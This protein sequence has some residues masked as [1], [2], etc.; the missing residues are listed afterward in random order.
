MRILFV[1]TRQAE[2]FSPIALT[3][4]VFEL[5]CGTRSIRQRMLDTL[6]PDSWGVVVRPHLADVYRQ[7]FP[8]AHV[9]D[10]TW[11]DAEE[12][13]IVN[14]LW[15]VD[16]VLLKTLPLETIF[17][18]DEVPLAWLRSG[19]PPASTADSIQELLNAIPETHATLPCSE[20]I[21][22]RYPWDLIKHNGA[23]L[24][25]DFE[26]Q[27]ANPEWVPPAVD[28]G[29]G[30]T[31]GGNTHRIRIHPTARIEP[32]VSINTEAGPVMID[33]DAH[34]QSF[35]RLEGPCYIGPGTQLFR[36]HIRG[37]TS[38][39][40][41]CRVGGEIEASILHGYANK[42]HDGFLGHGYICPW[43]NLGAMTTNSDLK[44]DYS[45]VKFPLRMEYLATGETKLG[46]FIGDHAKTA[47]GTLFNTGTNV[48]VMA[49]VLP[50]GRL[51]PKHIP[52]FCR[53]W[54]GALDDLLDFD[55]ACLTAAHAMQRRQQ[56]LTPVYRDMLAAV[57]QLTAPDRVSVL[58]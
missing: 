15:V 56:K 22:L 14:G 57:K 8:E 36:A 41:V 7:E 29:L 53:L 44:N 37:E 43:V 2:Q 55:A 23:A 40:P 46:C 47:I 18:R 42:Y 54:Q 35:T 9:N 4:P 20:G 39:G 30:L 34:I 48:G 24:Q 51:C 49:M 27:Q 3:R 11:I 50:A 25:L 28:R 5:M 32:F 26:L 21:L 16:P 52:S 17:R 13:L 12:L 38:I 1:E 45:E 19:R 31:P 33:R 6:R 58:M 10:P